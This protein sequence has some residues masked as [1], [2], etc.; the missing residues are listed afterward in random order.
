MFIIDNQ[1]KK[2]KLAPEDEVR[3]INP[4]QVYYYISEGIQPLR[5]EC[6]YDEKIVFVFQKE[7]TLKLFSK[8]RSYDTGWIKK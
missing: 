6:G 4:R 3:L 8:W 5:L 7:P 1:D 2:M